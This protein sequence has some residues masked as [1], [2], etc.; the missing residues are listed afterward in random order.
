L[1]GNSASREDLGLPLDWSRVNSWIQFS[2]KITVPVKPVEKSKPKKCPD[3]PVLTDYSVSPPDSF[4]DIFPK[5]DLPFKPKTSIN[6][7]VLEEKI[8]SVKDRMTIAQKF[9]AETS[10]RDLKEGADSCQ[11]LDLPPCVCK[12]SNSTIRYAEEV[13]DTVAGWI[14]QGFVCGPFDAPPLPRFRVNPL[15]AVEQDD[16]VR[17]V[18]NVSSPKGASFND[19]VVQHKVEKVN[20]SSAREVSYV[21]HETGENAWISKMD[22][23]DAYK[24]V[25]AP[26]KDLKLQGFQWLGKYF[27]ETQQLF[28]AETAVC[29]YDRLGNTIKT[30]A[31]VICECSEKSVPRQLDDTVKID[32]SKSNNCQKFTSTYKQLCK[33][34]DV[35]LAA[36]CPRNE[37]AF[38]NQTFGKILG[39]FFDTS[40]LSWKLPDEKI[41][42]TLLSLDQVLSSHT[43]D[44]L[45]MQ[46]L[47]GRLNDICLMCPFL[48][49]FKRSLNDD[50]GK[51]QRL[52]CGTKISMQ[53]RKDLLIW[54]GFLQDKQKWNKICPRPAGPPV[55][56]KELSSDAAGGSDTRKGLFGCG[57]VGF[58]ENGTIIF[59]SQ[60]FWP[61]NGLILK[62]DRKGASFAN[63]TTTLEMI[64]VILPFLLIPEKLTNQHIVVKVD[65]IAC[66]FGWY[67]RSVAGDTCA[68]ILIRALHL[69]SAY[70]GSVL[71]FE[72]L[73][74]VLAWDAQLVDRL[75]RE[76]TTTLQ[77]RKLLRAL[78]NRPVPNTLKT[79]LENPV[80]NYDVSSDLLKEVMS[81]CEKL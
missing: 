25:P 57:N 75:S 56:R 36:N 15:V 54:A 24:L 38:E 7:P 69:I 59:A 66:I 17:L 28:G 51:M 81:I 61:K 47:L 80:E 1:T 33:D 20:M 19:N 62:K 18:M 43:V 32:A 67:N 27:V 31:V 79:W 50:L 5:R 37:K 68:S 78:P 58:A 40:D 63:K 70:L 73:P 3:L 9:R 53:S 46:K 71:H 42:K 26:L 44:L 34:I 2:G 8:D 49:G 13:T 12:N 55:N 39:I 6:I 65:N 11:L 64:G 52:G 4:W 45:T 14:K 10:L 35:T 22:K 76:S 77:D 60:L 23:R 72:H 16:K 21:I 41:Y 30:I 74:R 29:N 48:N